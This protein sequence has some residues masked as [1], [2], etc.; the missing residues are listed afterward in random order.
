MNWL[1]KRDMCRVQV[2]SAQ[3]KTDI[4][5]RHDFG[6]ETDPTQGEFFVNNDVYRSSTPFVAL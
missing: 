2:A 3:S 1:P 5:T 4:N 6:V